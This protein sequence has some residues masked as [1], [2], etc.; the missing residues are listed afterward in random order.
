MNRSSGPITIWGFTPHMHQLGRN[1]KVTVKRKDGSMETPFDKAFD[2]NS[3][4]TYAS[5]PPIVLEP[6][7]S[8]TST[9]TFENITNASVGFGPS[10][11][12]EMC[13]NFTMAYPAHALDNGVISLI[14]AKNTCW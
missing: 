4:I 1:M 2:F 13:Y 14:G 11:T 7:D 9:C 12:Q 6:G 5:E 10:S 3:Q 8:I